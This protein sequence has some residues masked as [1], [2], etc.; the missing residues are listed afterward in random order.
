MATFCW[1]KEKIGIYPFIKKPER[2][3][4]I[5][6]G[7]ADLVVPEAIT[8]L[9]RHTAAEAVLREEDGG[10]VGGVAVYPP[11]HVAVPLGRPQEPWAGEQGRPAPPFP[12]PPEGRRNGSVETEGQQEDTMEK[13]LA[14]GVSLR[15]SALQLS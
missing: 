11:D 12:N 9:V 10:A 7:E 13:R 8:V 4:T 6:A 5:D 3:S 14:F 2:Y 15:R 1:K